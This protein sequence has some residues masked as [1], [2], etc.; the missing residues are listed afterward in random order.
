MRSA[1][2]D[3]D[4]CGVFIECEKKKYKISIAEQKK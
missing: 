4:E 2:C 3:G 1:E